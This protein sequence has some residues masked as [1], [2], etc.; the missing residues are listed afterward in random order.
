MATLKGTLDVVLD[1]LYAS[2][3]DVGSAEYPVKYRPNVTYST[4]TG[5]GQVNAMFSDTRTLAAS[6][7]ENLDLA[8]ALTDAFG[9][10]LT[11]TKIKAVIIKADGGNT[12]EVQVT[13]PASN[14]VPLFI[15]AG[16][17]ISLAAGDLFVFAG[18][19]GKTVTASTGDLLT[20]TNSSS[21][22]GVTYTI[23]VLGTV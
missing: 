14:G 10:T 13:R 23:I 1:A 2:S 20:I 17:G 18:A 12:N 11:F 3:L 5:T 16:D 21:G 22:T 9:N 7:T 4:G 8:A 6:G 19:V 15:A